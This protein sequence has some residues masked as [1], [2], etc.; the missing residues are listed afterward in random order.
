ML[1]ATR[2]TNL[3]LSC[4]V[5]FVYFALRAL[6]IRVVL[7]NLICVKVKDC[8]LRQFCGALWVCVRMVIVDQS[9]SVGLYYSAR[10]VCTSGID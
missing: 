7:L 8:L 4:F 1:H 3:T 2:E 5:S 9:M 10:S 6:L